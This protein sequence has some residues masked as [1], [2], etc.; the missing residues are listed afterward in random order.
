MPLAA[1]LN[2][3]GEITAHFRHL[4]V[5]RGGDESRPQDR[6]AAATR[7]WAARLS[8]LVFVTTEKFRA[9]NPKVYAAVVAALDEA[10]ALDQ[11]RQAPC[12]QALHG[13]DEGEEAERRRRGGHHLAR[14]AS[15]SPRCRRRPSSSPS[16][17]TAS[18]RFKTKPESWKDLYFAEAHAAWGRLTNRSGSA[19]RRAAPLTSCAW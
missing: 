2:P 3:V 12:R 4:A 7:S 18:A 16:S 5:P 9:A 8:N 6:D 19:P 15:I 11:R 14:R 17:C 13:D 1:V 10:I